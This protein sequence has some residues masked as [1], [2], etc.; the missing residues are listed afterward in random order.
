LL[1]H[2]RAGMIRNLGGIVDPHLY[3]NCFTGS[4]IL[5]HDYL[6]EAVKIIKH[7]MDD[8]GNNANTM[9]REFLTDTIKAYG[10]TALFL[11]GGVGFGTTHLGVVKAMLERRLLPR[12]ICGSAVGAVV[13][14]LVCVLD[15][16]ELLELL[17]EVNIDLS[18]FEKIGSK[19]SLRRKIVRFLKHGYLF[20]VNILEECIRANIGD[21]TFYEAYSRTGRELNIVVQSSRKHEVP[22]IL[23][24][25]TAPDVV[26]WSAA[27][28]S[29]AIP[30]L[31]DSVPLLCKD[32]K[33]N[34]SH[35]HATGIKW[36]DSSFQTEKTIVRLSELFNVNHII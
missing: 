4:K 24:H 32:V 6:K 34:L 19:G 11:I 14:S 18:A 7:L 5:I 30:G 36:L 35:W 26:I 31:Y 8:L 27:S 16:E 22:L 29:C 10:R 2:L 20:D 33:G 15:D 28:A 13:A 21:I 25:L 23:S 3:S 9:K 17:N 12:V 1:F